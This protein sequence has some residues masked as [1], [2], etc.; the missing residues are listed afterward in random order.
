VAQAREPLRQREGA[1]VEQAFEHRLQP[2]RALLGEVGAHERHVGLGKVV[3]AVGLEPRQQRVA[4]PRVQQLGHGPGP[5]RARAPDD[6]EPEERRHD[7]QPQTLALGDEVLDGRQ[8]AVARTALA[9]GGAAV[10]QP[11]EADP[12]L[13]RV[14]SAALVDRLAVL[15]GDLL[16]REVVVAASVRPPHVMEQQQ[17]EPVA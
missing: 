1:R 3:D 17:R 15:G 12:G 11:A 13:R 5:R 7:R 16:G 10:G 14:Q 2:R 8:H 9:R 4:I 6:A